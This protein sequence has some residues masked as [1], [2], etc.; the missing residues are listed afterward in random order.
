MLILGLCMLLHALP[1]FSFVPVCF[2]GFYLPHYLC[3]HQAGSLVPCCWAE[4]AE[5][6]M[7]RGRRLHVVFLHALLGMLLHFS[8]FVSGNMLTAVRFFKHLFLIP[9]GGGWLLHIITHTWLVDL[10]GSE[11]L[12]IELPFKYFS[13]WKC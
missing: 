5:E 11:F 1:L 9:S 12:S 3:V 10:L 7:G 2:L 4:Q 8:L 6:Q 13:C